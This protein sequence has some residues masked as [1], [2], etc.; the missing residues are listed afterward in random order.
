MHILFVL[1]TRDEWNGA[2]PSYLSPFTSQI[3]EQEIQ[4]FT[5]EHERTNGILITGVGP[6][7]AAFALGKALPFLKKRTLVVNIG[8]A[9]SFDLQKAPL[10]THWRVTKEIFPEY[11]LVTDDH[12]DA[13]ALGF[14][15][16][17]TPNQEVWDTLALPELPQLRERLRHCPLAG[18]AS[19]IT[20]SGVTCCPKRAE[21]LSAPYAEPL[22]ENME[23]F[24]LALACA[25]HDV[26][27]LEI[28]TVS[29]LV[30]TRVP[31]YR[32]FEKALAAMQPVVEHLLSYRD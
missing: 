28:R 23:G 12:T 31:E 26:P 6:I 20:V 27:L 13:K 9:G 2:K 7:N 11:G 5:D 8:L 22:L 21:K 30:G 25:R 32:A 4:Y 19:S 18:K 24:S 14:P 15:Q 1:A 29:N 3:A 10:C 16:W 17:R